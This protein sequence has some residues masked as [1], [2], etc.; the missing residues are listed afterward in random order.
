MEFKYKNSFFDLKEL[1]N[2]KNNELIFN[3]L[4]AVEK[5]NMLEAGDSVLVSIS[6]GPDSVFLLNFLNIIKT[7]YGLKL[8]A[9]H[10]DHM[11]RE[12]RSTKDADFVRSLCVKLDIPLFSE[13]IN[14]VAWCRERKLS[15]QEGARQLRKNLLEKY[16]NE[17]SIKKIAVAHNADDNIETFLMNL[18]RG[19]G[20]K[21]LGSIKPADEV[22]IRPL[23]YCLKDEIINFLTVNNIKYCVDSTNF[24]NKYFRN[25]IRNKL[26]PYIE[27]ELGQ[28]F[29][30]NI[31]NTIN[32]LRASGEYIE[33]KVLE[34]IRELEK[35]PGSSIF[36]SAQKGF[37]RIYAA[38]IGN[39]DNDLKAFLIRKLIELVKGSA[40]DII[41]IN[42]DDILKFCYQG[43]ESKKISLAAG[44][45]FVKESDFIYIYDST[46]ITHKDL[47]L[48]SGMLMPSSAIIK[49]SKDE[50]LSLSKISDLSAAGDN[51]NES[52]KKIIEGGYTL[53]IKIIDAGALD[54]DHLTR[55]TAN[56]AYLDLDKI[57]FPVLIRKWR[58]G[59]RFIPLGMK[60]EKKLQDFFTDEGTPLHLRGSVHVFCDIEKIIWLGC[61][62]IDERVKVD[63]NTRSILYLFLKKNP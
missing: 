26:I 44:L 29:K 49:I 37:L 32:I 8:F 2:L 61:Q 31:L 15:F 40:K 34:I 36:D 18:I 38:D 51:A 25:K 9:F 42:I 58:N 1:S 53:R 62:R 24:E 39:L 33:K 47:F 45:V 43:G 11:T 41:S 55:I 7:G 3:A 56:E 16:R 52:I 28:Q 30:K 20:L 13:K 10:L 22:L 46:K 60:N 35:T 21:G 4:N 57:M 59:D 5:H 23:I 63:K 19:S 14:A 6:G 54:K 48:D 12:G 50:I 27:N 17:T